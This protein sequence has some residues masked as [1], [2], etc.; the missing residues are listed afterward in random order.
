MCPGCPLSLDPPLAA[1]AGGFDAATGK[2]I[3]QS[4]PA[5][6]I[7]MLLPPVAIAYWL[8]VRP[9]LRAAAR[10]AERRP[11]DPA[12]PATAPSRDVGVGRL[13]L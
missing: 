13:E 1:G 11:R 5:W 4:K 7:A 6:F 3:G 8:W 9:Q 10:V 12:L 2:R